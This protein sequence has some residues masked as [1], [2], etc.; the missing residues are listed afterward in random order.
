MH[1][2]RPSAYNS[3]PAAMN[4]LRTVEPILTNQVSIKS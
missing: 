1:A 2:H 3:A 4:A